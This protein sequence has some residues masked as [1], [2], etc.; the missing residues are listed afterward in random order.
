MLIE[1]GSATCMKK[2]YVILSLLG[3]MISGLVSAMVAPPQKPVA[4]QDA[5]VVAFFLSPSSI[6]VYF[7]PGRIVKQADA[8]AQIIKDVSPNNQNQYELPSEVTPKTFEIIKQIMWFMHD[9]PTLKG[10]ALLDA[11]DKEIILS[12]ENAFEFLG[13]ANYLGFPPAIQFAARSI[14]KNP[15]L[16]KQLSRGGVWGYFKKEKKLP[17]DALAEVARYYFLLTGNDLLDIERNSYGFSLQEYLDYRPELVAQRPYFG[18]LELSKLRLRNL[19]GVELL[20]PDPLKIYTLD[21]SYNQLTELDPELIQKMLNLDKINLNEN[22]L[23]HLAPT[24]F[25]GLVKLRDLRLSHNKLTNLPANIFTGLVNLRILYLYSNELIGL[26]PEI[27][28]GLV[29]LRQLWVGHNKIAELSPTIFHGLV[30]LRELDLG[31]NQLRELAPNIFSGLVELTELVLGNNQLRELPNTLFQGLINLQNLK[32]YKNEIVQLN[33]EH[34]KGLKNLLWLDLSHNKIK[35]LQGGFPDTFFWVTQLRRLDLSDNLLTTI[36][37]SFVF[38]SDLESL[39]LANNR[40]EYISPELLPNRWRDTYAN[41]SEKIH[42]WLYGNSLTKQ[43]K[44][45]IRKSFPKR[46]EIHF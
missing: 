38:F 16:I 44:E 39:G 17:D 8:L 29:N 19:E 37:T 42:L 32:L 22:R 35:E 7:L 5:D 4:A 11:L 18:Q 45:E 27:F 20:I 2:T 41:S 33:S 26:S 9:K 28:Q 21:L 34:F 12:P 24:I 25:E 3:C 13:V 15:S 6:H 10:K 30:E 1:L 43:N 36:N 40:L 31:R 14:A 23:T 46:I